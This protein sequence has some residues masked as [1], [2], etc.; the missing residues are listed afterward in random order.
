MES[1]NPTLKMESSIPTLK[2]ESSI[3]TLGDLNE[4]IKTTKLEGK[5][6]CSVIRKYLKCANSDLFLGFYYMGGKIKT[7]LSEPITQELIDKAKEKILSDRPGHQKDVVDLE[8]LKRD[9]ENLD[10][11]LKSYYEHSRNTKAR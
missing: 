7:L 2:M 3:P 1:P 10:L 9:I 8:E 5:I 11:I 6:D 4:F